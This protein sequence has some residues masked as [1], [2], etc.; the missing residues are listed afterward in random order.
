MLTN[1]LNK[2]RPYA[3]AVVA[4]AGAVV[5]VGN[6]I[7]GGGDV[8]QIVIALLTALGVHQVANK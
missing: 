7:L 8:T 1:L 4:V 2:L 5:T 3:K 6:I